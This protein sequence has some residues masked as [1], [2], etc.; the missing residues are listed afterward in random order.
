MSSANAAS[1]EDE[2]ASLLLTAGANARLSIEDSLD[3]GATAEVVGTVGV[4]ELDVA[5]AVILV[6]IVSITSV[7]VVRVVSMVVVEPCD[8]VSVPTELVDIAA[9]AAP[10]SVKEVMAPRVRILERA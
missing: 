8:D 5:A 6:E 7:E 10:P 9:K 3:I 1:V 4:T 2:A